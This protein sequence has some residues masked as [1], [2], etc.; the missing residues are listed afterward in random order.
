MYLVKRS[1][2]TSSAGNCLSFSLNHTNIDESLC[3]NEPRGVVWLKISAKKRGLSEFIESQ[4]GMRK[5][6]GSMFGMPLS[7]SM[8]SSTVCLAA[9]KFPPPSSGHGWRMVWT[10]ID[11]PSLSHACNWG[12]CGSTWQ[13]KML[14]GAL[15]L[16]PSNLFKR[17]RIGRMKASYLGGS[18]M[19]S[20]DKIAA[21]VTPGSPIH[22]AVVSLAKPVPG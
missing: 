20:I 16:E 3:R 7:R 21:V 10:S 18:R 15:P 13:V 4:H 2:P 19:S 6:T 14:N 22:C 8:Q 11:T 17:S 12:S 5:H 9:A 1:F